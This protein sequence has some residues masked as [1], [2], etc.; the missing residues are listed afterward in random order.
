MAEEVSPGGGRR[1]SEGGRGGAEVDGEVLEG[2]RGGA[3]AEGLA[4]HL[5]SQR[6]GDRANFGAAVAA[7]TAAIEFSI[8]V[9][10]RVL[11][12][13]DSH[14]RSSRRSTVRCVDLA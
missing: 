6:R 11:E 12:C 9:I 1:L 10:H 13:C 14:G 4:P 3:E 2:S 7:P 8:F 5:D